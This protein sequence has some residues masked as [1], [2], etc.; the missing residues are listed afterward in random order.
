M[1]KLIFFIMICS[2]QMAEAQRPGA[3]AFVRTPQ[4]V[5]YQ[6]RSSELSYGQGV[7]MGLG[8]THQNKFLELGSFISEGDDHGYYSFFGSVLQVAELGS[9]V[10]L[11]TNWFGEVTYLPVRRERDQAEWIYSGGLCLFPNVQLKQVNIG[12]PL[13]FGLAGQKSTLSF[14]SRF[15]VNLSYRL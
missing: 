10:K 7:S 5:N 8:I 2:W 3:Y 11:N 14:N 9:T 13:C 12:M 4:S 6:L 1:N 15:M